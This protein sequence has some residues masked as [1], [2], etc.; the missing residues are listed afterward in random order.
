MESCN[1]NIQN[2]D[3]QSNLEKYS[4]VKTNN[5]AILQEYSAN[6]TRAL[7]TLRN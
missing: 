3:F 5:K 1:E 7:L 2:D 4:E 6:T